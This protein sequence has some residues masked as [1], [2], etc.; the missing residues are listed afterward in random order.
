MNNIKNFL[1]SL[2]VTLP[3]LLISSVSIAES[4]TVSF[5]AINLSGKEVSSENYKGKI[6]VLEWFNPGCPY[7]KKHYEP[8]NMQKLQKNYTAKNVVWLTVNSSATGKQGFMTTEEAQAKIKKWNI[9]STDYLVDTNGT[10]GKQFGAKT[11]PHM[12][13]IDA[14]GKLAY[15]GAIDDNDS[16]NSST[17]EGAKNYVASALD[18]LLAGKSVTDSETD[19]YG[20]SVKY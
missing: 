7:V 19:S 20:C 14:S 12:F 16:A 15:K 4:P 9:A 17:I 10:L 5:K 13:I 18:E 6:I 2:I 3:V 8:G 1:F 11:T